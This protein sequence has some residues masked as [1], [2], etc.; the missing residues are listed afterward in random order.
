MLRKS[1]RRS[2][3]LFLLVVSLFLSSLSPA[4]AAWSAATELNTTDYR[5]YSTD[6]SFF[7]MSSLAVEK[8]GLAHLVYLEKRGAKYSIIDASNE[9]GSWQKKTVTSSWTKL[10]V[11]S[12][13]IYNHELH[14]VWA[15]G[16]RKRSEIIYAHKRG[17]VWSMKRMT[18]DKKVDVG[19]T[20]ALHRGKVYVSWIKAGHLQHDGSV[21]LG[22]VY[23][24]TNASGRWGVRKLGKPHYWPS[25]PVM[26][27]DGRGA[28]HVAYDAA[29]RPGGQSILIHAYSDRGRWRTETV[30]VKFTGGAPNYNDSQLPSLALYR[31]GVYIAFMS[32]PRYS[33]SYPESSRL[34]LSVKKAGTWRSRTLT[35][36]S[37]LSASVGPR[38]A[39]NEGRVRVAYTKI[40]RIGWGGQISCRLAYAELIKRQLRGKT[41]DEVLSTAGMGPD[42]PLTLFMLT[43]FEYVRGAAHVGYLRLDVT[44]SDE[45][46]MAA[47][48]MYR[49]HKPD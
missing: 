30:P 25:A 9:T 32:V 41:F 45:R 17:G 46:K 44:Q 27:I 6:P 38:I 43:G 2:L 34:A 13:T 10:G 39:V 42:Q 28:A 21:R 37:W 11:P 23:I 47:R 8:N 20:I 14:V 12:A 4:F 26:K 1:S 15:R 29:L 33:Y 3:S 35:N 24:K 18:A 22:S 31:G 19:P 40:S 48:F 16:S 7:S 36:A 49:Q 5:K